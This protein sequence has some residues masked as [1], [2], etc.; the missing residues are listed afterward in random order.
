MTP[1]LQLTARDASLDRVEWLTRHGVRMARSGKMDAA[2]FAFESAQAI[3]DRLRRER[4]DTARE[5]AAS[6]DWRWVANASSMMHSVAFVDGAPIKTRCG[7]HLRGKLEHR[8]N[9]VRCRGCR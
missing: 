8:A 2:C 9:R 3:V 4:M 1:A 6:L 5:A 7:K